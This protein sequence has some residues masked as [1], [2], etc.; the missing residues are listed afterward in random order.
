MFKI[1]LHKDDE[2][3]LRYISDK[4]G[5]GSVRIYQD[6]CIF[7]VTDQMGIALLI[8]IFDKFNLNTTKFLDYLYFKEAFLY[9]TNRDKDLTPEM[10]KSTLINLKKKMNTSRTQFDRPINYPIN[11]TKSWLLGFSEG[12]GSFFL[13]RD[14]LIPTFSL[15]NSIIKLPLFKKIKEFFENFLGFDEYS[16][17]RLK[18]SSI[19][20]LNAFRRQKSPPKKINTKNSVTLIIKNIYVLNNYL[21]PFFE[22]IKFLSKKGEDFKY[23]K[24]M[25]KAIYSGG[26]IEKRRFGT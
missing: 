1:A 5:I 15:S 12:D 17:Y 6:Q 2:M 11:I 7:N 8:S 26:H 9:Y 4:L 22:D 21:I 10:V 24:I 20:A 16:L 18:N 19:I 25:C 13:R 14:N 23:F 3:V